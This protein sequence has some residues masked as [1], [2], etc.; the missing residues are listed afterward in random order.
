MNSL[1][2]AFFTHAGEAVVYKGLRQILVA[3]AIALAVLVLS[4]VRQLDLSR[5]ISTTFGRGFLQVLVAGALIGSLLTAPLPGAIPVLAGMILVA[6]SIS[7][8]RANGIPG[9][10]G[11]SAL[12]IAFGAGTVIVSMVFAGA[13]EATIRDVIVIGSMVIANAMKMN[14]LALERF[15]SEVVNHRRQIETALSVGA[16]P[17]RA[18]RDHLRSSVRASLIPI[19]DSVK[20]LGIVTIPGLMAG[21]IVSGA[22]PIYA[23]EYQFVIML[24]LFAAGGLTSMISTMLLSRRIFTSAKQIDPAVLEA[25]EDS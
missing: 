5:E 22:N 18:I 20:S 25:L 8:S 16:S 2:D 23:A 3:S 4:I 21:M 11:A 6:A 10:F 1:L 24:M 13:I 7:S 15:S 12:A 9:V 19:L 14:S 17:S